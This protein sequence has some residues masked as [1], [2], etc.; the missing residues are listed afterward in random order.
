MLGFGHTRRHRSVFSPK[1]DHTLESSVQQFGTSDWELI[2]SNVPGRS[3]R[4]CRERWFSYLSPDIN[5]SP[6]THDEDGLLFDL[7]QVHGPRWGLIARSFPHRTQNNV[8]NRWNTITRKAD[9]LRVNLTTRGDF[10]ET[11]Q[12]VASRSARKHFE[13]AKQPLG[14]KFPDIFSL[15]DILNAK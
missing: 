8:K 7:F 4:Q 6:W 1:E 11:G 10:I 3:A 9:V 13:P 5:L 14:P 2:S 12:K 15:E